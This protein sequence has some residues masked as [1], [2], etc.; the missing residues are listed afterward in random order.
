MKITFITYSNGEIVLMHIMSLRGD[1]NI[2]E[3]HLNP[4]R[5]LNPGSLLFK[6]G[7]QDH[8]AIQIQIQE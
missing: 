4:D 7:V 1:N 3:K 5:K 2:Q 8:Y 6:N